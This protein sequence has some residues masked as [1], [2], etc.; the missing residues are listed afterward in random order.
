MNSILLC[1]TAGRGPVECRHAVKRVLADLCREATRSDVT[2][3]AEPCDGSAASIIVSLDGEAAETF[4]R[5]WLG[6]IQWIARSDA[7]KG[8]ERKNWFVAIKR[9]AAPHHLPELTDVKFETLRT[10][11]PGGQH[12]NKTESAVRATHVAT[13]VSVV[14]RDGRSQHRNKALAITRLQQLLATINQR[15]QS[16][17]AAKDWL[18]KIV[19]ERGKPIR[20]YEGPDF[21]L[22]QG[23]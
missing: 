4:A 6:T 9:M 3:N 8:V 22:R 18:K 13:G 1:I 14:A 16:K 11:G 5:A 19:V 23:A 10:G 21:V 12:Q 20:I 17:E 7:R 2:V 15:H